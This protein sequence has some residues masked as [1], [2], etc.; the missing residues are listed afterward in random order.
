M[1]HR[2]LLLKGSLMESI[3]KKKKQKKVQMN[4]FTKQKLKVTDVEN[5]FMV[6]RKGGG[7]ERGG[8]INQEIK[9]DIYTH[10]CT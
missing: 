2:H 7:G 10:S 9:I 6:T 3:I 5:K 4:L 1:M 8:G